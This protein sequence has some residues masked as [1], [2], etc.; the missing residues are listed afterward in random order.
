MLAE[1][2]SVVAVVQLK[3]G[4]TSEVKSQYMKN[5][6]SH[7][8]VVVSKTKSTTSLLPTNATTNTS[9]N[10]YIT[11]Q[12]PPSTTDDFQS[13]YKSYQPTTISGRYTTL[14]GGHTAPK[15]DYDTL[16]Q[17]GS[18]PKKIQS[19]Y[20]SKSETKTVNISIRNHSYV[21]K[22]GRAQPTA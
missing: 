15:S 6:L 7:K 14:N 22:G 3:D 17:H 2:P 16:V 10:D 5:R 12:Y 13:V 19:R 20:G 8:N 11:I 18:P 9:K 4:Q 21:V 1:R